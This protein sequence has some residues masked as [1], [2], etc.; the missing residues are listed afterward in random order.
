MSAPVTTSQRAS[1]LNGRWLRKRDRG[2]LSSANTNWPTACGRPALSKAGYAPIGS[3]ASVSQSLTRR[4]FVGTTSSFGPGSCTHRSS[5]C[6]SLYMVCR[7]HPSS[8]VM[9]VSVPV[10]EDPAI[11]LHAPWKPSRFV[12]KGM[13]PALGNIHHPALSLLGRCSS[14]IDPNRSTQCHPGPGSEVL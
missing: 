13:D 7:P 12:G 11:D 10:H 2:V 4:V 5:G 6:V 3:H 14:R 8:S 1:A 9:L